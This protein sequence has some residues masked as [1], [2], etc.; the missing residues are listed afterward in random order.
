[1]NQQMQPQKHKTRIE[2]SGLDTIRIR[3]GEDIS[4]AKIR[5]A[6]QLNRLDPVVS[7]HSRELY[8]PAA[9]F[10]RI[11]DALEGIELEVDP[12]VE[13]SR[14]SFSQQ[15]TFLRRANEII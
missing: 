3:P 2:A 9:V 14:I 11:C 6:L 10:S 12:G 1:M 5:R 15:D 7:W 8:L 4:V 13:E